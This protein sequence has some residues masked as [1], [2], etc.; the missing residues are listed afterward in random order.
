MLTKKKMDTMQEKVDADR[1]EMKQGIRAGEEHLKEEMK[2]Q[3]SSVVSWMD[4]QH[5][6]MMACLG[7][8]E[9][10]GLKGNAEETQSEA[11]HREVPKEQAEAE[12]GR[13]PKKQYRGQNL[14]AECCSQ[15]EEQTQ[16]NGGSWK[17]LT[18][19]GMRMTCHA[20]VAWRKGNHQ[21]K[22]GQGRGTRNLGRTEVREEASAE[23]GM[24]IWDKEQMHETAATKQEGIHQDLQENRWTGGHEVNCQICCWVADNQELDVVE[25][26]APS[27]MEE[28]TSTV[29]V[30]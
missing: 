11:E 17:K 29:S 12:T 4:A 22:L 3:M 6:R 30:R 16:G 23:T 20:K 28:P 18:A 1:E 10:T 21:E 24:Q 25:G 19:T 5:E 13:A 9:A 8:M 7:R 26:S 14:A 27:K 15:P 2:A